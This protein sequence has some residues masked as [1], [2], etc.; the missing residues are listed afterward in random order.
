MPL[1]HKM[2][3]RTPFA[4][5]LVLLVT[6]CSSKED[7]ATRWTAM[8]MARVM[9]AY[10]PVSRVKSFLQLRDFADEDEFQ[11]LLRGYHS[12]SPVT[13]LSWAPLVT[14]GERGDKTILQPT[15]DDQLIPMDEH[16]DYLPVL[17]QERS[18]GAPLTLGFDLQALPD[19]KAVIDRA[20]DLKLPIE[21]QPP[22]RALH[23]T[24]TPTYSILWPVYRNDAFIGV[25]AGLVPADRMADYVMHD[26]AARFKGSIAFFSHPGEDPA[27]EVP[28]MLWREG[29]Y[30]PSAGPL[31]PPPTG[32]V[33]VLRTFTLNGLAWRLV[34]DLPD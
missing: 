1:G 15:A 10:A 11:Q 14:Q 34:F 18:D 33:R 22:K 13:V 26:A 27:L 3:M 8:I 20:R 16:P 6:A 23:A 7:Q 17:Y 28:V 2:K 25:V 9:Q 24:A 19:R 32:T 5:L 29:K 30:Q 12:S 21:I 31:G 4:V